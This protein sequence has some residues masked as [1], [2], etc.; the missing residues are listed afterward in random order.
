M[1]TTRRRFLTTAAAA[2]GAVT[3]L[4]FATRAVAQA[5]HAF[6]TAAGDITVHPVEHASMRAS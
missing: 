4:P 5:T 3:F 1:T 2:A 6:P